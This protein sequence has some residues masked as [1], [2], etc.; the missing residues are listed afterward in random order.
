MSSH[1]QKALRPKI[2]VCVCENGADVGHC[3]SSSFALIRHWE[4]GRGDEQ[5]CV[6]KRYVRWIRASLR[7]SRS[8]TMTVQ[9]TAVKTLVLL[10]ILA[11]TATW[12]WNAFPSGDIGYGRGRR[13]GDRRFHR[14][15]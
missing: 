13:L 6:F 15:R 10:A 8:T 9:G 2:E 3:P 12:S 11:A 1:C 5:P 7:R 14:R 4:V